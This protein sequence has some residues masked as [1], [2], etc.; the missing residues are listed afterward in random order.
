M[1]LLLSKFSSTKN[2]SIARRNW[3][4]SVALFLYA[5]M[6]SYAYI[7]LNTGT[8]ALI[9]FGTVQI[10]MIL[11]SLTSGN[12]LHFAEWGG[13]VTAFSGFIY[14]VKPSLTTP[15]LTGFILMTISGIAW[16]IYTLRGK[17]SKQPIHDSATNF[18]YTFPFIITLLVI[19]FNN[20]NLSRQG[21][22][23]ALVSG[24]IASGIGYTVWYMA[25]KG[26]STMQASVVQLFVPII[27]AT[28]GVIFSQEVISMRL[29]LSSL[30]ILGGII[31]VLFGQYF[32]RLMSKKSN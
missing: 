8:G 17:G 28:G 11:A 29:I 13:I 5:V 9:L 3:I 26:L 20:T 2:N 25:V 19:E 12:R 31:F 4:S 1:L 18:L 16:G 32:F 10:T 7:S 27:A 22:I 6:F 14:L 30:M 24:A 23:L 15:S 21:I